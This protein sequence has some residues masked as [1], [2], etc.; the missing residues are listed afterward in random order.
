MKSVE[1]ELDVEGSDYWQQLF[2][3][4]SMHRQRKRRKRRLKKPPRKKKKKKETRRQKGRTE[5]DIDRN[6]RIVTRNRHD[7]TQLK[8]K[9]RTK[10]SY[11]S[12]K[13]DRL[14]TKTTPSNECT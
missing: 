5:H 13:N 11:K 6:K 14:T 9:S 8:L 12:N 3:T 10:Q 4:A 7:E 1:M 2:Q